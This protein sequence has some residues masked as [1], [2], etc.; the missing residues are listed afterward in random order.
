[1]QQSSTAEPSPTSPSFAGL[2]AALAA[3]APK[4]A[5]AWNDDDLAD[6]VAT[7][8]YERA[9]RA[10]AR[11]RSDAPAEEPSFDPLDEPEPIRR[12]QGPLGDD[13]EEADRAAEALLASLAADRPKQ[14]TKVAPATQPQRAAQLEKNLKDASITIRMSHAESEQLRQR[15]T[16]A[17]MTI[18]AYLRSCTFEVE[19]LRAMVKETMAQLRTATALQNPETTAR[20]P[21]RAWL[22]T[23]WRAFADRLA[24]LFTPWH[25][26]AQRVARA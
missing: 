17:G 10:R 9:L 6:D 24:R 19:S 14:E 18:S 13:F 16:E 11:Y 21:R 8:S 7:L 23:R 22:R 20:P 3:P 2:L 4:T 25:G 5:P 1:M 26:T 15:A 12:I